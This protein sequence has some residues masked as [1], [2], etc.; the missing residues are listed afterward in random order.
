MTKDNGIHQL[1]QKFIS[2]PKVPILQ[3]ILK[4]IK[5]YPKDI[6]REMVKLA[7]L[8]TKTK[9]NTRLFL[10]FRFGK[11]REGKNKNKKPANKP[12]YISAKTRLVSMYKE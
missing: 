2:T 10:F 4:K 7:V 5:I 3:R 12:A 9:L 6:I 11:A 1:L 8:E